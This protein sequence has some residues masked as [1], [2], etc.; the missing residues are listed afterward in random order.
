MVFAARLDR[1]PARIGLI[2]LLV[3]FGAP[4][5]LEV[6]GL[7][8]GSDRANVVLYDAGIFLRQHGAESIMLEPIGYI[9]YYSHA[10]RVY[11]LG[12]LVSPDV[13]RLRRGGRAGWFS[14]AVERFRPEYV[15]LRK[16]EVEENLGWNVG[17][18]FA[19]PEERQ[20][21]FK[22]YDSSGIWRQGEI[23]VYRRTAGR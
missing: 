9:G 10:S 6:R 15:V 22:G 4:E 7:L 12:G 23:V 21:W 8:V 11:D 1:T 16:G 2:L 18:L 20:L 14:E 19:S 13:F 17:I 5:F 3:A